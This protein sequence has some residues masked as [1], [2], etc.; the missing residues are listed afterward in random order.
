MNNMNTNEKAGEDWHEKYGV[1]PDLDDWADDG[2][3]MVGR[4]GSGTII[5]E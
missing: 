5:W 4:D 2:S 1:D 3:A